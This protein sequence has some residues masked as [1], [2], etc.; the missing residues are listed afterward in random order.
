MKDQTFKE[1]IK[2]SGQ[3]LV[4][5]VKKLVHE[6]NIRKITIKNEKGEILFDLPMTAASIGVILLPVLAALGAVAALVANCTIEIEK[7]K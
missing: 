4:A 1:E 5:T 6:T 3:Q 7:V 2:V